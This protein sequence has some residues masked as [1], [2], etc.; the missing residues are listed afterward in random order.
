[1][2]TVVV[3]GY[4]VRLRV[5]RELLVIESRDGRQEIPFIEI[6]Q[7]VI[8]TSGV[9]FSSKLVRKTIEHGID[10]VILDS[11]GMPYGRVYPPF[12][13]RTVE[14]RRRQ[15][16]IFGG[17]KSVHIVKEIAYSK[18]VNQ[19]SV[20]KRYNSSRD[21]GL[22]RDIDRIVR[23]AER[24]REVSGSLDDVRRE[25]R[26]LEAEAARV[27][28]SNYATLLPRDTGFSGRDHDSSD[29]VNISLNYS[30]GVLY[31]ETWRALVLAGLDPYAGFLHVDRSGK[32]V[33]AFDFVEMFRFSAD[34]TVLELFRRGWRPVVSNGLL[35]Y[36]SRSRIVAELNSFLDNTK[37]RYLD[38]N[39]IT[40]RQAVKKTAAS[41]ASYVRGESLFRGFV[42]R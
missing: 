29:P 7:I 21:R 41:L 30:Y 6:D 31:A 11:R 25:I 4:G 8:A 12:I 5:K 14:T 34:I 37:V 20:L 28:W 35:D 32:P 17:D 16:E 24:V 13:S 9:W 33:L 42:F 36:D 40:I 22:A 18:M 2:R 3:S 19:A 10:L 1:M 39:P 23:L 26:G 15:Y 27:Y 38:E